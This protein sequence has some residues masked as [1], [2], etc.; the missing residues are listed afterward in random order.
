MGDGDNDLA[1]VME[2]MR[3]DWLTFQE[4]RYV[5]LL[6]VDVNINIGLDNEMDEDNNLI[7]TF[8]NPQVQ[9]K[10]HD[11]TYNLLP[12]EIIEPILDALVQTMLDCLDCQIPPFTIPGISG[13]NLLIQD[14]PPIGVAEDYL[15]VYLLVE[16]PIVAAS[17]GRPDTQ[18]RLA[19]KLT[20][21]QKTVFD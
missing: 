13:W 14:L 9:I 1:L 6:N 10:I 19:S 16:Q 3:I 20:Q 11:S 7:F 15:G 8:N 5:E 2:G 18:I 17:Q 12:V 21:V 4:G